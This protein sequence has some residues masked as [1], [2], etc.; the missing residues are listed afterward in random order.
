MAL[1]SYSS[2]MVMD[3]YTSIDNTFL[4]EFLPSATG[5][6][7]KVYLYGLGL[8]INPNSEDNN[9]DTIC[10]VLGLTEEQVLKSFSY[11][12]D[13]G[14][15]QIVS[16]DPLE[17]RYLPVRAHSGGAKIRNKEKYSDFNKQ[18]QEV[19]SGRMIT[20]VEYNEYYS[21][22]ETYHFEPEAVV[23]IAKYC[24]TVKSNSVSYPYILA[25]ARDFE[26]QGLKTLETIEQKFIEQEQSSKEIKQILTTLGIKR[27][28]DIDERNLYLKWTNGMGFTQ[29]VIVQVA[30]SLKKRGGFVKLDEILSKYYEQNL[31]S[32]EE[33]ENYS[34]QKEMMFEIAKNVCK[35]LGLYYQNLENV[36]S[37][38]VSD[39]V[40]KGYDENTLTEISMFCFKQ[41]IRTLDAMSQVVQKFYKLGLISMPAITQYFNGVFEDNEKIKEIL[42]KL[43]LVRIVTNSDRDFY[44]T[45]TNDWGFNHDAIIAVAS[46]IKGKSN[47]FAYMNKVLSGLYQNGIFEKEKIANYLENNSLFKKSNSSSKSSLDYE[48]RTYTNEE[49]SAV[50]DSL[51][52]VEV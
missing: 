51:D 31:L 11:W 39:W 17:I 23:L 41:N 36:V 3:S 27:E 48:Q 30:K 52:D 29:G 15:V 35:N 7:V 2:K 1:C 50:F 45:W 18:M 10:K 40:N 32:L 44:K 37:I 14:L 42:D 47:S 34:T 38:Y 4:N 49:L 6:D 28:A 46:E 21:L 5:E 24:T 20:P 16:A 19:L 25:V 8:C 22:I 33:I 13:M 12:Q 9:L 43:G 26:H